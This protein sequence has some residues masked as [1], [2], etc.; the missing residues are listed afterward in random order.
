MRSVKNANATLSLLR[1]NLFLTTTVVKNASNG[2]YVGINAG[3]RPLEWA[4]D[5]AKA[6][7]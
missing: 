7:E 5:A 1:A 3:L 6:T 4:V 2:D